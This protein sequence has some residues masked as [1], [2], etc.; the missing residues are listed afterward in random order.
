MAK[1]TRFWDSQKLIHEIKASTGKHST[2]IHLCEKDGQKYVDIR[3]F[4][5]AKGSKSEAFTQHTTK[6]IS[7]PVESKEELSQVV[8]ALLLVDEELFGKS[9]GKRK[10]RSKKKGA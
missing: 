8:G 7:L 10:P 9:K 5:K 6:G 2:K 1:A 3:K 4:V